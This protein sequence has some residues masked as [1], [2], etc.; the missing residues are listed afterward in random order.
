MSG[1]ALGE[2]QRGPDLSSLQLP[3]DRGRHDSGGG[4]LG[5]QSH[6]P[7]NRWEARSRS[8]TALSPPVPP[9]TTILDGGQ[10]VDRNHYYRRLSDANLRLS[11]GI[12]AQLPMR[13]ASQDVGQ[14]RLHK[15]YLG[16]D[17]E[18]LGS[19]SGE[20]PDSSDYEDRGRK[21]APRSL[22][23]DALG[24]E[25]QS[26]SSS[27]SGSK[28]HQSHSLL[29]AADQERKC[30]GLP[31]RL[32]QER[33]A[34]DRKIGLEVASQHP[35]YQYRSLIP[36]LEVTNSAGHT[37]SHIH[38]NTSYDQGPASATPSMVDS[39]EEADVNDIKRAQNLSFSM[40][41]VLNNAESQRAIRIIY[42][43]EYSRIVQQAEEEHHRLRKYLVATDLSE[44]STH[45][46]EW[47]IGTVLRD[48]DTLIAIYCVDAGTGIA[49]SEV[50]LVPEDFKNMKEQAAAIT[51]MNS[52]SFP[53]TLSTVTEL[54]R[55]SA[56]DLR[57]DSSGTPGSSPKPSG[58]DRTQADE[59]RH[60]A[61]QQ[62]TDRVVRLLRKTRLQVRVIVEVLHCKTPR[63]MVT[64]VIDL[65]N[66]TLVVIGSRGRSALQG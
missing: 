19:S 37:S 39:D 1:G 56:M 10:L 16:P 47:A 27:P 66:P 55:A 45:A 52:R 3:A 13:K 17:G 43:G 14:G 61:I 41:N 22:S 32:L 42:R 53:A 49:T 15:D 7:H 25:T 58:R 18:Q 36:D 62:M 57:S 8:P 12:L 60:Q 44:E 33:A 63:Y 46:L 26:K 4:R 24:D 28:Q 2:T 50:D 11:S 64:E 30:T 6:S 23:P 21:K 9:N 31:A 65:V 48:G 20:E 54:K 34:D 40:T 59:E 38:P 5:S 29:A 35:Q 51:V